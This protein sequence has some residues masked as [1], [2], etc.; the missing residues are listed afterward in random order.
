[1]HA[2]V[3]SVLSQVKV[4]RETTHMQCRIDGDHEDGIQ[5]QDARAHN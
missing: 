2:L 4:R 5:A 1:M 3:S